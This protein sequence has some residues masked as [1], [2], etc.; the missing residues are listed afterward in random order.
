M[1]GL[2]LDRIMLDMSADERP[3]TPR[4]RQP[5][6]PEESSLAERLRLE[7]QEREEQLNMMIKQIS[8]AD[9]RVN[10]LE[11]ELDEKELE[12]EEVRAE[13]QVLLSELLD[14]DKAPNPD[15]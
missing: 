11:N 12:L 9:R 8:E 3:R 15:N 4:P 7:L 5:Q 14:K 1:S 13:K 2:G 10:E 6:T